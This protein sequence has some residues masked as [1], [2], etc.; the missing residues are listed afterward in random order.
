MIRLYSLVDMKTNDIKTIIFQNYLFFVVVQ[1]NNG[2]SALH[3]AVASNHV[4]ASNALIH[5][6]KS[7]S[8]LTQKCVNT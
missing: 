1:D 2:D 5:L 4:E 3:L 8:T 7:L 6:G